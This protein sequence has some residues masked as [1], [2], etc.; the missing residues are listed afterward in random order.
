MATNRRSSFSQSYASS[1]F[2]YGNQS[3]LVLGA[4]G[5]LWMEHAVNGKF[6]TIPPTFR[7][8]VDSNV[9][10]FEAID[11]S[12][13]L[14]LGADGNLWMEHAVKGLFGKVP[15]PR[16]LVDGNV[17]AFQAIDAKTV[18]VLGTDGKLWREHANA[19]SGYFGQVPLI[20]EQVDTG[21]AFQA[22]DANTVFVLDSQGNLYLD[23]VAILPP[24]KIAPAAPRESIY[25]S[26]A[27]FQALDANTV[28]ILDTNGNLILTRG[29][30]GSDGKR[31]WPTSGEW[32]LGGGV[33]AFQALDASHPP[34]GDVVFVVYTL[35]K[36]SVF[37]Q[38]PPVL[39]RNTLTSSNGKISLTN[40]LNVDAQVLD[41]QAIEPDVV[42]LGSDGN[43]WLTD[44]ALGTVP[45]PRKQIDANVQGPLAY[46]FLKPLY[47]VLAVLYAPP[48][49]T[50]GNSK[51]LADYSQSAGTGSTVSWT[52]AFKA[53]IDV[54]VT[55]GND[56][57][58]SLSADFN[59]SKT[60]TNTTW[61][62]LRRP[63]RMT[64]KLLDRVQTGSITMRTGSISG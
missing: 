46:G 2:A 30:T 43:L 16:E 10:A 62:R 38:P 15:Q 64:S 20:R 9:Q 22:L 11:P 29:V 47:H 49:T 6:G 57:V 58:G 39:V 7:Q 32:L 54:K 28:F 61:F 53:G 13:V 37:N 5:N 19:L 26:V 44:G 48:G 14:V 17:Q 12:T 21:A 18:F 60:A 34:S 55:V 24:G 45:P 23:Q 3:V 52:N 42:I 35:Y 4:D 27:A 59:Y 25:Q 50:G 40:H 36:Q 56:T 8:L 1:F 33:S 41:F 31:T 51:S 63:R